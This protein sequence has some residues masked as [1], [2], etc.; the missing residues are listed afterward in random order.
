MGREKESRLRRLR[1]QATAELF[2]SSKFIDERGYWCFEHAD[3]FSGYVQCDKYYKKETVDCARVESFML[4]RKIKRGYVVSVK[5]RECNDA[6]H[7]FKEEMCYGG[8]KERN[9]GTVYP[10]SSAGLFVLITT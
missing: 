8:F 5:D 2:S 3:L 7:E 6:L 1:S 9:G 4:F 10:E